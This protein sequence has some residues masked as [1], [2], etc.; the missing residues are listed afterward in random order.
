MTAPASTPRATSS[1]AKVCRSLC[2]V[3]RS[4]RGTSPAL[5]RRLFARS[6][7]RPRM[8]A[9]RL[10]GLIAPPICVG[11]TRSA[12]LAPLLAAL[13]TVSS[14]QR[15]GNRSM[16]LALASVLPPLTVI[17]LP[18][19]STSRQRRSINSPIR[20]PANTSVERI[21]RRGTCRLALASLSSS[22]AASIR[23]AMCPALSS[24][25]GAALDAFRRRRLPLA[26]L[27][28]IISYSTA[29]SRIC[30]RRVIVLLID[31]DDN[32]R[33]SRQCARPCLSTWS[34][35]NGFPELVK[36][37]VPVHDHGRDLDGDRVPDTA[38]HVREDV[39]Q[40]DLGRLSGPSFLGGAER[41]VPPLTIGPEPQR[42]GT[43]RP[44]DDLARR[45]TWHHSPP[46]GAGDG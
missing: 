4:G 31:V 33:R 24:H 18:A 16:R 11:K 5:S 45:W 35:V 27:R 20:N 43:T 23:A 46:P 42:V 17:R 36:R 22:S 19:R 9:R 41:H 12:G 13:Y 32:A 15:T 28:S 14:L 26:G 8:R 25:T 30:A 34:S 39:L 44:S 1:D 40:L 7:V 38:S 6:T 3:R 37:G 29:T 2:G 21:A 10:L